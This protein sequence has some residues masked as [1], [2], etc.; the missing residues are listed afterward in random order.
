MTST[1]RMGP[2]CSATSLA[3]LDAA[4][5]ILRDDGG[6]ALTSRR[7]AERIG[8]KQRLVYYYFQ[9]MDDLIVATFRRLAMREM[10][11]LI[12]AR[13]SGRPLREIWQICIH[14][15]DARIVAEFMALANRIPG[16]RDEVIAYIVEARRVQ[17]EALEL[18]I[19]KAGS[20]PFGLPP[21]SLAMLA[22]SAALALNREAQLGI[23]AGH[24]GIMTAIEALLD[25]VEPAAAVNPPSVAA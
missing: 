22:S 4:E 12:A 24:A 13:Q 3:M 5:D 18:A 10:D 16:L 20:L 23:V 1:R 25:R 6:S 11:R 21:A 14:T 8:V 19:A 9:T 7:L 15:S 2:A 17:Q